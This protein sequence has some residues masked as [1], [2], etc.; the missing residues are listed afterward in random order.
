MT[1]QFF[2][3]AGVEAGMRVLD[4]G[5]GAGDV[6]FLAAELVG[7]SGEVVGTDK[8]PA[9]VAAAQA[10]AQA[11]GLK[12]VSFRLGDPSALAFDRPFDAIV[13]RYVLMFSPDPVAM[14]T[15]IASHLRPNGVIVFHE[16]GGL[17]AKSYPPSPTYD[18]CHE[19]IVQ[20]FRKVGTNPQMCLDLYS[21]F[22]GAG[23]PAP[24]M[25]LQ[26]LVGG[27]SSNLNGLDMIADLAITMAPVIEQMG[28]A[29]AAE[30]DQA[31]LHERMHAEAEAIG[32]I[33][34]GRYEVGAWTRV[35]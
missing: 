6:A 4:I 5:S 20:T 17:G 26:T 15:G 14:L 35:P 28:V 33:V 7:A 16:A 23:F 22:V 19:W 8:A 12:N 21:A 29:T 27:S 10:G 31:T 32:S 18:R 34:V 9:A 13:G 24:T 25:G 1:R 2:N 3:S 30:I 11:R